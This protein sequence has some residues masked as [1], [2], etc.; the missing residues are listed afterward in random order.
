M[1]NLKVTLVQATQEWEDK[2]ANLSH[3][4]TL[5]DGIQ[6]DTDLI[7]LPEMFHTGFSMNPS[8]LAEQMDNSQAMDWLSDAAARKNAAIYTSFIAKE[9]GNY[10][11]RGIFILPS[12]EF[13]L[14]DKRKLF[15]LA[16]E[17][18]IFSAGSKETVILYKEWKI[19]LQVCYDLRFPEISR[20]RLDANQM[21]AYD[22]ILYVANWPERRSAHWKALLTARAIENQCYVVGVN[23]V[24]VDGNDLVYSG[25][26]RVLDALGDA[27]GM[28]ESGSETVMTLELQRKEL[29]SVRE[30][31]SFLK[32]IKC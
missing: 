27:I 17:D 2:A 8:A 6:D 30:K 3:F 29:T 7:V 18:E 22:V 9:N 25:D 12:G 11:N 24:G 32:D 13:H 5:L 31:L 16:G 19:Q 23:R 21:P 26:S 14:Y 4:S 1:Q 10:Y 20:N 28:L 15:S